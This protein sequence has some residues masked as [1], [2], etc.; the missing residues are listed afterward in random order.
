MLGQTFYYQLLRKYTIYFGALFSD[1]YINRYDKDGNQ[2]ETIPVPIA[3]GPVEKFL[4]RVEGDPDLTKPVAIQLPRL[5]FE[6]GENL[7]YDPTRKLVTTEKIYNTAN[8]KAKYVY[9]PVPYIIDYSLNI[10]VEFPEDARK[11]TE[12]ILPYFTPEWTASLNLIPEM[13]ISENIPLIIK[14]TNFTDTYEGALQKRRTI[15]WTIN[16]EMLVYFY[17]PISS[18]QPIK[19]IFVNFKIPSTNTIAEGIGI[20]PTSEQIYI[21]PGL[22]ANGQP[23]MNITESIPP[24]EINQTDDWAFIVEYTGVK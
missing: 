22:T 2:T 13:G 5:S 19:Q 8:G 1:I 7:R 21:Q 4:A 9:Q 10:M 14:G 12:Q 16:F 17:G 20:T 18:A 6:M 15:I 3:Y 23:T 11:I 24:D